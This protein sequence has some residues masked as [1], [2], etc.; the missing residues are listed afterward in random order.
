MKGSIEDQYVIHKESRDLGFILCLA[1]EL[2][3]IFSKKTVL[4]TNMYEATALED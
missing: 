3:Y 1:R 2:M 4:D